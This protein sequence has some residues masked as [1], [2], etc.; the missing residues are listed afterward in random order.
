MD[1]GSSA[2]WGDGALLLQSVT[3][4]VIAEYLKGQGASAVRAATLGKRDGLG[5]GVDLTYEKDARVVR[6]KV[7][8]DTYY[9]IDR[10]MASDLSLPFYRSD[11]G[12]YALQIIKHHV[13][14]EPG[15]MVIS[16]AEELYYYYVVLGQTEEEMAALVRS[17]DAVFFSEL[18]VVRDELIVMPLAAVKAWFEEHQEEFTSRPVRSGAHSAWY[19]LVPR[20][21][22]DAAVPSIRH[23]GSVFERARER[24]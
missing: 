19:R 7:K 5:E 18:D 12:E 1:T 24:A 3:E 16:E 14:R 2:G 20:T 17:P 4:R 6:V 10:K 22:L 8:P 15:W 9:G 13:T 11:S 21:V 23:V